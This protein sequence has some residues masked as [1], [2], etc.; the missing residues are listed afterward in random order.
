M[1][2]INELLRGHVTLVRSRMPRPDV[3]E[4]IR[5]QAG[6]GWGVGPVSPGASGQTHSLTRSAGEDHPRFCPRPT[7]VCRAGRVFRSSTLNTENGKTTW[8]SAFANNDRCAM[9][10]FLLGWRRRRPPPFPLE[11]REEPSSTRET[12]PSTSTTTTSISTTKTLGRFFSR[13]AVM[14]PGA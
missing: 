4:R 7:E 11:K 1:P 6:D 14:L 13:F 12:N 8:P 5:I 10:S 3:S 2:N 9:R